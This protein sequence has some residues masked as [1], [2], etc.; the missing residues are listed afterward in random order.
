MLKQEDTGNLDGMDIAVCVVDRQGG[1]LRYAGAKNPLYYVENGVLQQIKANRAS[2]GGHKLPERLH[3]HFTTHEIPLCGQTC[4]IFSDGYQDQI[5]G[6]KTRKFMSRQMR[7]I[8][9]K[10]YTRPMQEQHDL[11]NRT[12]IDWMGTES[13]LDDI[14]VMGF[15]V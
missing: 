1:V 11:L 7:E 4:Y 6:P 2:I 12:L 3:P 8:F 14:L 5:G 10:H 9:Q 15:K 13:Q